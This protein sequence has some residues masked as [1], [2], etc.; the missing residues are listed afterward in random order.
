VPILKKGKIMKIFMPV[1][2]FGAIASM[3]YGMHPGL[4]VVVS[5]P[6]NQNNVHK[7]LV[8]GLRRGYPVLVKSDFEL[9]PKDIQQALTPQGEGHSTKFDVRFLQRNYR[10]SALPKHIQH[11]GK[12]CFTAGALVV[13]SLGA[14]L[15][16]TTSSTKK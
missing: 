2:L 1:L 15:D 5:S 14:A 11:R 16:Y 7:I 3:S 10:Q 6:G 13:A 4:P 12:I 8:D 9:N